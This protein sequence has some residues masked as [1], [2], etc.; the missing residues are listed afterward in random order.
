VLTLSSVYRFDDWSKK[1]KLAIPRTGEQE[2]STA[3]NKMGQKRYRHT[4]TQEAKPLDPKAM[5]YEDKLKKRKRQEQ[6]DP[7]ADSRPGKKGALGNKRVGTIKNARNE[8]KG[9][10]E[11]RRDRAKLEQ[12]REKNA[13]HSKKGKKGGRR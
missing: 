13:R 3:K 8:L 4:A 6:E 1:T 2:L 12:R 7:N 9:T 11:I 10:D 5:D